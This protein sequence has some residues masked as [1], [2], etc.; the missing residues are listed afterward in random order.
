MKVKSKSEPLTKA[1]AYIGTS[2]RQAADDQIRQQAYEIFLARGAI[3]G[4]DVGD[5]LRAERELQAKTIVIS[6][7]PAR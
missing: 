1:P 7:R 4:Q 3:H 5:W 6:Y 2:R